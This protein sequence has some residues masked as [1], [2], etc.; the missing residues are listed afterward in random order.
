MP[1]VPPPMLPLVAG[2]MAAKYPKFRGKSYEDP[3][4]HARKFE[5][6]YGTNNAPPMVQLHKEA[7]FESTLSGKAS[8]W[9]AAFPADHFSTYDAIRTAF[10]LV[11][12]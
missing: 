6:T 10:L 9:L 11:P 1:P 4:A 12:N 2:L 7:V 8:K 3:D 5:K